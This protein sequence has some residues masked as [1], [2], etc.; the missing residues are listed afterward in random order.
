MRRAAILIVGIVI[1][2]VLFYFLFQAYNAVFEPGVVVE[3][4]PYDLFVEEGTTLEDVYTQLYEAQVLIAPEALL[5]VGEKKGLTTVRSGHYLI[6]E[7]MSIN[8][9]INMFKAGLQEPVKVSFNA[10]EHLGDIAAQLS[11]QLMADS[12]SLY[13]ALAQPRQGWEGP[14]A[15]GA[16]LPDT[17][18][19]YW[20][21]SPEQVADRIFQN[22]LLFWNEPRLSKAQELG[23]TPSQVGTLAS[24]VMK[25][26]SHAEDRKMVA[27]LYLNRL[28]LGM[29]L[30]S[31]PTVIFAINQLR[32]GER[33]RRVLTKDLTLDHPY[34]TY[35]NTG[36]PPGPI[37]VPE[38]QALLAVLEAKDHTY[39]YMCA[40]PDVPG[41][42][43]YAV[44][45]NEH[46]R[47][48][49]RWQQYLDARKIYR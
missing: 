14:M 33:I 42:H 35:V 34:N 37:C 20:N 40:N 3:N 26:S 10:G 4:T 27:G 11:K 24:V 17:Y 47:N 23:L 43:A 8:G 22:T 7:G 16:Y 39:L 9:I 30:Q 32:E 13:E 28:E 19:F 48:R 1:P 45:Y 25:E 2:A 21:A 44:G 6:E 41:T 31:D 49:E 5:L 12:T 46:L 38:K 29:K 18:E 36:L 15:L